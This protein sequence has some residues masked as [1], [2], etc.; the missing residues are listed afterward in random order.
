[1]DL[2]GR[3][4]EEDV[5]GL[6]RHILITSY[7]TISRQ[8]HRQT[9]D[10]AMGLLLSTVIANCYKED[11]EAAALESAPLN[12]APGFATYTAIS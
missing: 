11:Y 3:H 10:V 6:F 5:L 7:F 1:M 9:D 4:F 2:L 12:P 8:L